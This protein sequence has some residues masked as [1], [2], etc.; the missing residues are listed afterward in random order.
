MVKFLRKLKLLWKNTL[1]NN[2]NFDNKHE[3]L[4]YKAALELPLYD[5][6]I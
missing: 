4:G 2:D 6:S 5:C 3:E 1:M